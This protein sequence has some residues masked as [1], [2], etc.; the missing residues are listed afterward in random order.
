M[1]LTA[2]AEALQGLS[3]EGARDA[4]AKMPVDVRASVIQQSMEMTK[5]YRWVPNPG[6]QLECYNS[7]AD[8][9]L[10]GGEPGGGKSQVGIGLALNEHDRS[11]MLRRTNREASKFIGEIEDIIGGRDL[12]HGL[13]SQWRLPREN[14]EMQIVDIGGV[15]HEDDKQKFKGSPHD[16][17]FFDE[18]PDFSESQYMFITQWNRTTKKG[19]RCRIVASSNGPSN[20]SGL[21][22]VGRWAAWL[23]PTH[24][25]PAA[26]GEIRWYL[27]NESGKEEEVAGPGPYQVL[28]RTVRAT[29]RTFIR[30]RLIDNPDLADSNYGS[31]L[32]NQ[33][34]ENRRAYA[35]GDFTAGLEDDPNQAI[36]T[37]WVKLAMERWQP[38]PPVGVPMCSMGADVAQGGKDNTTLAWR[39]D[40]WFAR[41]VEKP[42]KETKTGED[43]AGF[44]QSRRRDN[45]YIVVDVGGGWGA[46]AYGHLRGNGV[47]NILAY[48]G[49]KKSHKRSADNQLSFSNVR[50]EAYWRFREALNP[51]QAGGSQIALPDDRVLLADLCAPTYWIQA[52]GLHLESKEDVVDRLGRSTDRG[53]AVVMCWYAGA[54]MASDWHNWPAS[55]G[56]N[57]G[58][59]VITGRQPLSSSRKPL[60]RRK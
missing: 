3:L 23:D 41:I 13:D 4:L 57:A 42:G 12:W 32:M 14:G 50:T 31:R 26:S 6:P 35:L 16:L 22:V 9:V 49:V 18:L 54:R 24:P 47:E 44:V 45:C 51:S 8:E 1:S 27:V 17:I 29:S 60:T 56:R 58:P 37:E 15:Q 2:L 25:N 19:Q 48:M 20:S 11:L 33:S 53:D 30:S 36:P 21:W 43:V 38:V 46:E 28:G 34:D 39:H 5:A 40:S 7:E 59:Q 10:F 55:K 52:N